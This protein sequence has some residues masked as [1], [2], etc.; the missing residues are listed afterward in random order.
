MARAD[1]VIWTEAGLDVH[2]AQ[3]ERILCLLAQ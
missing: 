2:A 3:I 1:Y